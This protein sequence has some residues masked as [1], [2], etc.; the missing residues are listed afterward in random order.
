MK[1]QT[2][3][4]ILTT[5][6][7]AWH[8][9]HGARFTNF[10]GYEMPV[11][12]DSARNEHLAVLTRAGLFDTSHMSAV[13]VSGPDA[14]PCLQLAFTRN[15]EAG[16][17]DMGVPGRCLYGA[18]LN[19]KGYV[20][21]D[22]ILAQL[23]VQEYF[24]VVNA[25]MGSQI[26][27]HIETTARGSSVNCMDLTGKVGKV[28]LQGPQSAKILAEILDRSETVFSDLQYFS[29]K[30]HWAQGA[31]SVTL[32]DGTDVLLLRAGYTGE[33]GFE[34]FVK[35]EQ[36]HLLWKYILDAGTPLGI[37]ACG[38]ASRDSL[39]TGAC[40][41]LSHQDI[42]DW[43]FLNTPWDVALPWNEDHD[44]FTKEFLGCDALLQTTHAPHT[45]PFVG[46][47]LRKVVAG[48]DSMVL[49]DTGLEI[50]RVLTCATDVGIDWHEGQLFSVASPNSPS[51]FSP[52]GLSC[53]FVQVDADLEPGTPIRLR[54]ARRTLEA[55]IFEDIRPHRSARANLDE[56]L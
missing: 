7:Y 12:Y 51:D 41:P 8:K 2:E 54:D 42:G 14:L 10:S 31:S 48:N 28:D 52:R 9:D 55:T 4:P 13:C 37:E 5:P 29:C 17:D 40:L 18:F 53:G 30:G 43:P 1:T 34:L 38:L 27:S 22:A 32:L 11:W 15:L 50:G 46:Q 47:D 39:R 26:A 23:D 20:V 25:G 33:L 36:L 45:L 49:S 24:V 35:A 56:T 44:G 21:D 6:L 19:E 3:S 16:Q